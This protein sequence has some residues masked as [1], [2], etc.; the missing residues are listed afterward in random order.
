MYHAIKDTFIVQYTYT[1][2]IYH[3]NIVRNKA[4]K[5]RIKERKIDTENLT[6]FG[7]NVYAY[8][9]DYTRK[10][11]YFWCILKLYIESLI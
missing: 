5:E 11:L 4:I 6:W 3:T 9:H 8:V 2:Y 10:Y 1:I 7:Y